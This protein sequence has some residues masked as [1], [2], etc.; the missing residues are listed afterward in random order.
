MCM[1]GMLKKVLPSFFAV[2]LVI[3][4]SDDKKDANTTLSFMTE[5][6]LTKPRAAGS[7]T[8]DTAK[9]LIRRIKFEGEG[10][11]DSTEFKTGAMVIHLNLSGNVQTVSAGNVPQGTYDRIKFE[12]HKADQNENLPDPDF[13]TGSSGN[14]RYSMIIIGTY[15]STRFVFRSRNTINQSIN[16]DPPLIVADSIGAA[17]LTL[18]VNISDWFYDGDGGYFDPANT[19]SNNVSNIEN[20]IKNSF[21]GFRD[22]DKDGDENN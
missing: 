7:L 16:I 18:A 13:I 22:N 14:D 4:C 8:I 3:S 2:F 19:S 21:R 5:Q 17:N 6:Y 10:D 15:N 11:G 20:T 9:I 1:K 12:I